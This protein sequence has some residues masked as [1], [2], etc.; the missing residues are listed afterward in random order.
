ML[1]LVELKNKFQDFLVDHPFPEDYP[2]LYVPASYIMRLGGKRVRPVLVLA[3]LDACRV[4]VEKGFSAAMAIELFHNFSL[5]HDDIMDD[6]VIRR[7]QTTVHEKWDTNTAILSGDVMLI[8]AYQYLLD[9]GPEKSRQ[10]LLLFNK[11]AR[12]VCEGQRM[13]MDFEIQSDVE[14]SSYIQMISFKTAVLLGCSLQMG[15]ILA[16]MSDQEQSHIYS[17]GKNL[18]IAFQIQDDLID[19]FGNEEL[20]GKKQGGDILQ[21]KK[22]YLY[23]KSLELLSI[24][25][26][27]ELRKLYQKKE[28]GS[29][30]QDRAC[31]ALIQGCPCSGPC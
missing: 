5:I 9:Y 23:L 6:A 7:G 25:E 30:V 1:T 26:V 20:T 24:E 28:N 15:G 16:G 11:T 3:V 18:G 31:S 8:L 22:T 19:V 14:I 4:G 29:T 21:N 2:N 12:E 27:E 10:L 13:D 17:F